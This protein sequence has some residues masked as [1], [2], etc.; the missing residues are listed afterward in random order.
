MIWCVVGD[1]RKNNG[2]EVYT[3]KW[4]TQI[5]IDKR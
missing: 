1:E 3:V 2:T 5:W 4:L